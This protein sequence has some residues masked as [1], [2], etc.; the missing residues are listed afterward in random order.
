MNLKDKVALITGGTTGIGRAI[1][2]ALAKEG[3]NIAVNYFVGPEE[4]DAFA[5]E[6]ETLG[7]KAKAF[8]QMFLILNHLNNSLMMLSIILVH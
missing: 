2:L 7:V 1:S 5:K 6:L 8:M 3:C 4:A